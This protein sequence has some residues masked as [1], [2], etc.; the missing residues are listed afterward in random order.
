LERFLPKHQ[1]TQRKLL[2]FENWCSG[3]VSK[4]IGIFLNFFFIEEYKFRST[5]F[6]WYFW[7]TS[8]LK[9]LYF[10]KRCPLFDTLPP[11][12]FAKFKNF[13][14]ICFF[15]GKNLSNFVSPAWKLNIL[16][17]CALMQSVQK[18][19]LGKLKCTRN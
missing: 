10:L 17:Y 16:P 7:I 18:K 4:I 14:W 6:Y 5:F 15:L 13:L 3:E 8:I 9:S 2:N 1:H 19:Q 11:H 12:Q